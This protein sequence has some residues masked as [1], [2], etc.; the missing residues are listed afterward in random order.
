MTGVV[1]CGGESTRMGLDK[2]MLQYNSISWAELAFN[3]L[4][5]LKAPVVL[6]VN[7]QQLDLYSEAFPGTVIIKDDVS[8]NIGGPLKG[9][10]SVHLQ[11]LN[12]DLIVMACDMP[13]MT[14]EVLEQLC[15][16]RANTEAEAFAFQNEEHIETLCAIYTGSG[17][18]KIHALYKAGNLKRFSLHYV[19][20]V[21]DS[22]YLEIPV[23]WKKYFHNFNTPHDLSGE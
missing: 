16:T 2:G 13:H 15:N 21:L 4:R 10:L 1:L 6:S 23:E 12:E 5:A 7:E 14:P 22:Y 8:L 18:E 20:S 17:L 11:Q 3:K 19:L 9:I